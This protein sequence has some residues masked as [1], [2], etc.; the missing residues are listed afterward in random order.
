MRKFLIVMAAAA[1]PACALAQAPLPGAAPIRFPPARTVPLDLAREAVAAAETACLPSHIGVALIDAAV[2]AD[3]LR[4]EP[5]LAVS[6]AA[7]CR[8]SAPAPVA[9]ASGKAPSTMVA[10]V[11]NTGRRRCTAASN[12]ACAGATP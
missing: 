5:S 11:I 4:E 1:L 8:A 12:T 3:C 7:C 2:L 9:N 6:L 10:V